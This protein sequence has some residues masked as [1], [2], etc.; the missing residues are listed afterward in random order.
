MMHVDKTHATSAFVFCRLRKALSNES[1]FRTRRP[2]AAQ[3]QAVNAGLL[4]WFHESA[5][6]FLYTA[7]SKARPNHPM[8]IHETP[9]LCF[10]KAPAQDV[11]GV[12]EPKGIDS[13]VAFH[14]SP[15]RARQRRITS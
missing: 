5:K 11:K 10:S 14:I 1:R 13:T 7:S 6:L 8:G 2:G 3:Q 9:T 12:M 15:N 4:E